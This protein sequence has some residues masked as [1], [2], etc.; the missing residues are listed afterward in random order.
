[1]G[2]EQR[3]RA[4]LS[5]VDALAG[6]PPAPAPAAPDGCGRG[7]GGGEGG[8]LAARE[9]ELADA[10]AQVRARRGL[11]LPAPPPG[12]GGDG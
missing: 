12:A 5:L 7:G 10:L 2:L 4:L 11:C 8:E 9:A 3:Q 6:A 1:V